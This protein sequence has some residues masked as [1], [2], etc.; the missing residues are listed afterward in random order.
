MNPTIVESIHK[1]DTQWGNSLAIQAPTANK[2][3]PTVNIDVSMRQLD[4]NYLML[5]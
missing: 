5:Y 3:I 1:S 4:I 2:L